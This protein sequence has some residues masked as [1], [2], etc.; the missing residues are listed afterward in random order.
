MTVL[1][2]IVAK[3]LKE[4]KIEVDALVEEKKSKKGR[5]CF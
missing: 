4:F 5:G 2:T 1:N 3:Q